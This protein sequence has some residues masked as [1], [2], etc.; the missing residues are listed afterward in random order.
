MD[1]I[2]N[3]A[4]FVSGWFKGAKIE[5]VYRE[6]M[7]E[8]LLWAFFNQH[9]RDEYINDTENPMHVEVQHYVDKFEQETGMSAP[10]GYN[11]NISCIRLNSDPVRT[12][13]RPAMVYLVCENA[14]SD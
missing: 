11:P 2:D 4:K 1:G 13:H 10:P 5:E 12:I 6:N 9:P 8:W 3:P 7:A 14:S